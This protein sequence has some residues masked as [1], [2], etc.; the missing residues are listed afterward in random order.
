MIPQCDPKA[1]YLRYRSEINEAVS[2]V[3]DSGWYILGDE[4]SQFEVEFA[5]TMGSCYAVAVGSGTDAIELSLR[6]CDIGPGDVVLTVAN[7]AVATVAAIVRAGAKPLFIDIDERTYNMDPSALE[8][9]IGRVPGKR[10]KAVVPVH[11]Y[12]LPA[13]IEAISE[14][15]GHHGIVVIEDCAQAHGA[16]IGSGTVGSFGAF[17]CFSFYPTKNLGAMGD[18]GA[19]VCQTASQQKTLLAL[20]QYGWVERYISAHPQ[21]INSRL[22]EL[23][24]AILR[25]K[26]PYLE[27]ANRQRRQLADAYTAALQGEDRIAC[28]SIPEG[29]SHVFHQYVIQL[30]DRERIQQELRQQGVATAV[31]YPLPVHRQPA[32]SSP[33][34]SPFALPNTERVCSRILSLPM[35]PELSEQDV[36][37]ICQALRHA[38]RR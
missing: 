25:V 18:G 22:D 27:A 35:Y 36:M 20:R 38:L 3:L 17:G 11:L 28:P 1:A 9:A 15:A 4:V 21:G 5:S 32:F 12:G 14:I 34:L 16:S 19:V 8:M 31:H 26:L 30:A 13:K 7:T 33:E 24:A 23:Q 37:N 6:A 10:V 29:C 2:R